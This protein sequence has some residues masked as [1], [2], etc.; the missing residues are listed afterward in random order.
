VGP[1]TNQWIGF[2][3]YLYVNGSTLAGLNNSYVQGIN[4]SSIVLSSQWTSSLSSTIITLGFQCTGAGDAVQ[5]L[6]IYPRIQF[7]EL[8]K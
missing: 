2:N 4:A 5:A 3:A 8:K 7:L 1:V 6:V